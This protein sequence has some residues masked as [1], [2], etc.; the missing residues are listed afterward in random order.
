MDDTAEKTSPGRAGFADL[1]L[2]DLPSLEI[3]VLDEIAGWIFSP[4]NPG[5]GY[6]GEHGGAIVTAVL[7]GVQRAHAFQPELAPMTSPVLTEMRDR[8]FT[9]VQELSQSAEALS[10]FVV[11]LMPAVI[12]ELER[13]AG[14]A[15]SQCYWL[16]CY[17]LLVLAG[18]RSGRL[19][20]SLMAGIIASFDGWNDLMSGG[21]TLPWRAA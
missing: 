10:T 1:T 17:A 20:E 16:Y 7:N 5:Q 8:V 6:S 15:A 3:L 9:G 19:D 12:S 11:T 14:D 18:G 21:F 13:S 4:E 2:R